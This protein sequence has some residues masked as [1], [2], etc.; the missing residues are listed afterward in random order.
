MG[1]DAR[2]DG[3]GVRFS[4]TVAPRASKTQIAGLL[5]DS[6]KIRLAAPPV[7]GAANDEL[8]KFLAKH[9]KTPKSSVSIPSGQ[10]SKKKTVRIEGVTKET[11]LKL[12]NL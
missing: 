7:D 8:V 1:L 3:G 5:G 6:L 12:L 10:T 4:V 11:L 2:D 9:F